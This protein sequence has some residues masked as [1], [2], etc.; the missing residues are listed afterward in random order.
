MHC[1]LKSVVCSLIASLVCAICDS[2]SLAQIFDKPEAIG[3]CNQFPLSNCFN[4]PYYISHGTSRPVISTCEC[5]EKTTGSGPAGAPSDSIQ[6]VSGGGCFDTK[7]AVVPDPN[8]FTD[9]AMHHVNFTP[10]WS[11]ADS[12]SACSSCE[13][14]TPSSSVPVLALNATYRSRDPGRQSSFGPGFF[15]DLDIT[16]GFSGSTLDLHH[17]H[18]S[19]NFRFQHTSN[20]I[21]LDNRNKSIRD[22]RLLDSSG[23]ATSNVANADVAVLTNHHGNTVTFDIFPIQV[24]T[25]PPYYETYYHGRLIETRDLRGLGMTVSYRDSLAAGRGDSRPRS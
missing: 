4:G 22:L 10:L 14:G 19:F 16:L 7:G 2:T 8:G 23:Y 24:E 5:K 9:H 1:Y 20:G 25:Y 6:G 12:Q 3:V 13:G 11:M 18:E 17:P 21:Y 15:S